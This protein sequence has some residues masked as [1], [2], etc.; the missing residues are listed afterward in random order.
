MAANN[1]NTP[2]FQPLIVPLRYPSVLHHGSIDVAFSPKTEDHGDDDG[3]TDTTAEA[4]VVV[5]ERWALIEI[6][7]ELL[8]PVDVSVPAK[9]SA[10]ASSSFSSSCPQENKENLVESARMA[11]NFDLSEHVE[12]GSLWFDEG[13]QVRKSIASTHTLPQPLLGFPA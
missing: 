1:L 8:R 4:G 3:C 2:A 12:L 10:V 9:P 13:D 7:G 5:V 11:S 6:N